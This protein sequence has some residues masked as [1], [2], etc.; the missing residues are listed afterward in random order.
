MSQF[1]TLNDQLGLGNPPDGWQPITTQPLLIL[2]GVTGVGKTTTVEALA[3]AGVAFD[4]LPNRRALTDWI[5]IPAAQV[6]NDEP[7]E[8]VA[9]RTERFR[10]TRTYRELHPGG[11]ADALSH[12]VLRQPANQRW[13]MFDGL[14]G[15]NEISAAVESLPNARFLVLHAPDFVRIKRLL[16][17]GDA[18]D[19]VSMPN[20]PLPTL[21]PSLTAGLLSEGQ[22]EALLSQVAQG[23]FT[24][25]ELQAK[26]TI[27][28]SERQNYD[29][30][31]ALE[32][33]M[34]RAPDR[35]IFL[36]TVTYSP[37]ELAQ[38][39]VDALAG[40]PSF[41]KETHAHD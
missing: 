9:E 17:R 41:H 22:I 26:L 8:A 16:G 14:R 3:S 37:D 33:L 34:Q 31:A 6:A 2:V 25:D 4:L 39:V 20:Q 30:A 27:V 32:A 23:H 19:Q 21:D 1:R 36:D 24:L 11:M 18:F 13:L 15:E 5:L 12:L 7:Q 29:P 35:T 40:N 10:L 38:Q 28:R